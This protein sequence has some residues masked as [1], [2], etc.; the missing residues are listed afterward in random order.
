MN[1]ARGRFET[2]RGMQGVDIPVNAELAAD[3][4]QLLG[5][6]LQFLFKHEFINPRRGIPSSLNPSR[7]RRLSV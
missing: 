1:K 7:K 2:R 6:I 5:D 3:A 4:I